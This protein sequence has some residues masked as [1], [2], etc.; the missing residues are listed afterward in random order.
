MSKWL[1]C[2]KKLANYGKARFGAAVWAPASS[3]LGHLGAPASSAL[4]HLGADAGCFGRVSSGEF[5][6]LFISLDTVQIAVDYS[7]CFEH[8]VY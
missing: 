6:S 2:I 1:S 4:S 8:K 7:S 3:A 5:S